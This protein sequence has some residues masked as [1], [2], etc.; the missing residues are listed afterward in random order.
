M[1]TK[2]KL[3]T[4]LILA[5]S[6]GACTAGRKQGLVNGLDPKLES[7]ANFLAIDSKPDLSVVDPL[8]SKLGSFF[9]VEH[10][11][12]QRNESM[13]RAIQNHQPGGIVFWNPQ[14]ADAF[15]VR[16][17]VRAYSQASKEAGGKPI[18]FSADYEGGEL[19][20]TPNGRKVPGI[21]RFKIGFTEL[22]HPIWLG[23]SLVQE[24]SDELCRLHAKIMAKELKSVGINYPLTVTSDLAQRLF[25]VR[26]ISTNPTEISKCLT[27]MME[28]FA[29]EKDIV[30]VTKHFPG[31]GQTVGDTH[32]Q[33]AVSVAQTEADALR[34]L[35]PFRQLIQTVN[36]TGS[37]PQYSVMASHGSFPLFD[38]SS[39]TTESSIILRD[40]LRRELGFK[41]LA[42]SDAMWMG[43]YGTLT[44][45]RLMVTYLKAFLAGMDML[46]IPG[47]KFAPAVTFFRSV[48]DNEAKAEQIALVEEMMAKPWDEVRPQFNARIKESLANID[49]V[50]GSLK[51]SVDLIGASEVAPSELTSQERSRYHELLSRLDERWPSQLP[52]SLP[53]AR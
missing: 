45:D 42:V 8:R 4:Y 32:D 53:V 46:M 44:G 28:V 22:A 48:Y 2:G 23:K 31:L 38:K 9:L 20:F 15:Q 50:R 33:V 3:L 30:L 24:N 34:H 1:P 29:K 7:N 16:D 6:L 49:R 41:G 19:G 47:S 25:S 40:L 43:N 13:I 10:F 12:V 21:Q 37:W 26:G 36:A 35:L 5:I 27:S 51:A 17:V 11:T 18:L 52:T 39:I 14:R